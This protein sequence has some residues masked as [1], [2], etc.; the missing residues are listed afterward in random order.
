MFV[1]KSGEGSAGSSL[2]L[3]SSE[4]PALTSVAALGRGPGPAS[5]FFQSQLCAGE[6]LARPKDLRGPPGLEAAGA[7]P[8][9]GE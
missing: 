3:V 8:G 5:L 9:M 4:H 2:P 1:G 7:N 6:L